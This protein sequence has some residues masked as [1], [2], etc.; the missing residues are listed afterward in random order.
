MTAI[1]RTLRPRQNPTPDATPMTIALIDSPSRT[2]SAAKNDSLALKNGPD[3]R[4]ETSE[5]GQVMSEIMPPTVSTAPWLPGV[6]A[7]LHPS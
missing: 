6:R 7:A 1:F 5:F 4:S 2:A 3:T